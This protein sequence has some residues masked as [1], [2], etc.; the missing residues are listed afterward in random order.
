MAAPLKITFKVYL[1][2]QERWTPATELLGRAESV[3][4]S[5]LRLN[6]LTCCSFQGGFF[7]DIDGKP[8]S[9]ESTVDEFHELAKRL[10]R[11]LPQLGKTDA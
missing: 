3:V 6:H 9:D 8:W 11:G 4:D 7:I 5:Y 2:A 10:D 1:E